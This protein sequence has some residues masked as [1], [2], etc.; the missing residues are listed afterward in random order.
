MNVFIIIVMAVELLAATITIVE[1]VQL[2][3]KKQLN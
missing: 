3:M 1:K 2:M